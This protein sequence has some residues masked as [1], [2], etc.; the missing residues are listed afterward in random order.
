MVTKLGYIF[1]STGFFLFVVFVSTLIGEN[2]VTG[3]EIEPVIN[4]TGIGILDLIIGVVNNLFLFTALVQTSSEFFLFG[5]VLVTA[6]SVGMIWA[7][8]ELLRGV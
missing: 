3:F 2:I 8:V 1:A 5:T 7:I 6:Y 4:L